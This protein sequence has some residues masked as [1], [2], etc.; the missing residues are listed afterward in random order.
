MALA[1][2]ALGVGVLIAATST[3]IG[4]ASIADKTI[5]AASL[6]QSHLA[7]V[8]LT[9][10]L[11]PGTYS[12]EDGEGF[13]WRAQIASLGSH[14]QDAAGTTA[15]RLYAVTIRESWLSGARRRSVVLSSEQVG[16]P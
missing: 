4:S 1:I 14:R 5:N 12:G 9:I 15:L 6:C 2:A 11:K 13:L 7:E 10:P 3:G 8:G 16:P